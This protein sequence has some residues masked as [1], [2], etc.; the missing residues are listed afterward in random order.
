[1]ESVL[2]SSVPGLERPWARASLGS[3][4]LGS[5]LLKYADNLLQRV[6]GRLYW[7]KAVPDVQQTG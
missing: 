2:G 1:M 6:T 7:M 3:R 5:R 4:V